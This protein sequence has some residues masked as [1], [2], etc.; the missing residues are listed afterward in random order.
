MASVIDGEPYS[1]FMIFALTINII[2]HGEINDQADTRS[3]RNAHNY[4]VIFNLLR[5]SNNYYTVEVESNDISWN[6]AS[7][8]KTWLRVSY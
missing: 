3:Y 1:S 6:I 4:L 5:N 7:V 2:R 8:T